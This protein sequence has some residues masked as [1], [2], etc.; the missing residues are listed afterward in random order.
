MNNARKKLIIALD[1][2]DQESAIK[3]VEQT[4]DFAECYKVGLSLFTALGPA[5]IKDLKARGAEVFLDLK[6][7]DIPMQVAKAVEKAL[8]L[9]PKFLTVHALGGA[10]MLK[11]A[12]RV[13][14]GSK[15]TILAV[16]VLTSMD[17]SA[18][19]QLGFNERIEE[20]VFRLLDM[21]RNNGVQGFVASPHEASAL[22]KA[23]PGC[24]LVCPGVRSSLGTMDDQ[25]RTLS[26]QEAIL[27]GADYLVVGRP[28][29]KSEDVVMSAKSINHEIAASLGLNKN[30]PENQNTKS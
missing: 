2:L 5:I 7:H 29:T 19:H 12:A 16:S 27:A 21:A 3:I 17:A 1:D 14:E 28:I 9:E 11:E 20:G 6:L 10:A 26:A 4:L 22:K 23:F 13:A 8:P 15:T 25:K 24:T 30:A 18:W